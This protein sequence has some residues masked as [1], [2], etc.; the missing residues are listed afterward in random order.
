[1]FRFFRMDGWQRRLFF[2][3]TFLLVGLSSLVVALGMAVY[4]VILRAHSTAAPAIILANIKHEAQAEP[5]SNQP[6]TITYCPQ[7]RYTS[8]DGG[9][10]TIMGSF[11]SNPPTF[12]VGQQVRVIYPLGDSNRAQIADVGD[13]WG[14]P[15]AFSIVAVFM[16]PAGLFLLVRVRKQGHPTDFLAVLPGPPP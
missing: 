5:D 6:S 12:A 1:M 4:E 13:Q 8:S 2:G 11:C 15:I 7:F 3:W 9:S 16:I 14:L 10:H